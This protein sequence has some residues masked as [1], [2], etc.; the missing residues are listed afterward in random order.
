MMDKE[1][2]FD[3]FEY[4]SR[5][6]E[7]SGELYLDIF[8]DE[9]RVHISLIE[10]LK[11][12]EDIPDPIITLINCLK[13]KREPYRTIIS[14]K[15]LEHFRIL[16]ADDFL[17]TVPTPIREKYEKD[18]FAG[19][20]AHFGIETASDAFGELVIED[21]MISV[22]DIEKETRELLTTFCFSIPWELE[23]GFTINFSDDS[24][25]RME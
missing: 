16:A 4:G 8:H 2:L 21:L 3:I 24:F 13:N 15:A 12:F 7:L 20:A 17:P 11:T 19:N 10:A 5:W 18:F 9:A 14:E 6:K 22:R 23:H 25:D 1:L